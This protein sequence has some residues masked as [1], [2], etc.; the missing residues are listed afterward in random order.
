MD[1][2]TEPWFSTIRRPSRY[3]DHEIGSIK[4]DHKSVDVSIALAF[5]DIYEVGMSHLG[6]RILYYILN[7]KDWIAAERVFAP[8]TDLEEKLRTNAM[9]LCSLET[10]TPLGC[11][12]IVG[13]SLQHE[14]CYTN[15]LN[16]L[17]LARIPLRTS[18]RTTNYPLIIAGGPACFNPEPVGDFF[19]VIVIGDGE[20]VAIKICELVREWKKHR[21]SKKELLEQLRRFR[22]IYIPSFFRP[23]FDPNGTQISLQPLYG[24]YTQVIKAKPA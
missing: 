24:D 17:D 14:L 11:F 3:L 1:I 6:L 8:W 12:D 7:C 4:K 20:E 21:S 2:T 22:G 19:D 5:P 13:F 18:E 10:G 16:M 9:P 23:H 15:V